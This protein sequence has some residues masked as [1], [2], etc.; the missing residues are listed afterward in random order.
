MK[1]RIIILILAICLAIA[2]KSS[3]QGRKVSDSI[4]EV[5]IEDSKGKY[6]LT[7]SQAVEYMMSQIQAQYK[8]D[9]S[10]LSDEQQ[11]ELW[12]AIA[13]V[14]RTNIVKS[15]EN[16]NCPDLLLNTVVINGRSEMFLNEPIKQ[17]DIINIAQ[18]DTE[19]MILTYDNTVIFAPFCLLTSGYTRNK[20]DYLVKK[21]CDYDKTSNNL[22]ERKRYTATQFWMVL[23]EMVKKN[24]DFEYIV[25]EDIEQI[26]YNRDD[27]DYV[28]S[29]EVPL[30][31]IYNE[32]EKTEELSDK[33]D[34][35][36]INIPSEYVKDAFDLHSLHF[37]FN[38]CNEKKQIVIVTKGIGDGY[39]MSLNQA[40]YMASED[41]S[42]ENILK[43]FYS[44]IELER[45]W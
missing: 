6:I 25:K 11:K 29:I 3:T 32:Y 30:V 37:E 9:I 4:F 1:R 33:S 26:K 44:D 39:G 2:C 24:I 21:Q 34:M 20:G 38:Y 36:V 23:N 8:G 13:I 35:S 5:Q 28:T 43:Y 45:K 40:L 22:I 41:Y 10:V 42:F 27:S 7:V 18:E 15:W 14:C 16:S 12:K 19:G 17:T 31:K